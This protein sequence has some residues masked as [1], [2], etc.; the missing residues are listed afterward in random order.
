M[1][2]MPDNSNGSL[3]TVKS[4]NSTAP[5]L[6]KRSLLE[7]GR[8]HE[9]T[10]C[11]SNKS[12]EK[13]AAAAA[14]A[15]LCESPNIGRTCSNKNAN[16]TRTTF[17]QQVQQG[18][19]QH[20]KS[21]N[22]DDKK[23]KSA[24]DEADTHPFSSTS[25]SLAFPKLMH[26]PPKSKTKVDHTYSD[27]SAFDEE[28]L[29]L[30]EKNSDLTTKSDY[31]MSSEQK[32]ERDKSLAQLKLIFGDAPTRKNSGGVVQPFPEKLMEVLDRGDMEH[33]VRWMPHGRSFLVLHPQSFVKEV[34]PR[35]FKQSKFMSFTR[36]LNLW[37]FKRI[38]KGTESGSYYHELFL[39][40]RP[41]LC[42]KMRRQKN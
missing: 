18:Q 36:Q 7:R 26:A 14:L 30:L 21:N 20:E 24:T 10:N 13:V 39:R 29:G 6:K 12:D 31:N 32:E 3:S 42:M 28:C 23:A 8:L 1:M 35:F 22:A 17:S 38:T 25:H 33:I 4:T 37:G 34:L 15:S 16:A 5:P 9:P 40:G 41:R 19:R 27:Y 2:Q 11:R